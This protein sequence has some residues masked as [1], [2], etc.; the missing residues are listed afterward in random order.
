MFL[1]RVKYLAESVITPQGAFCVV[2]IIERIKCY[3]PGKPLYMLYFLGDV[4]KLRNRKNGDF[5]TTYLP[6][7]IVP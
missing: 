3:K 7:V 1:D 5:D 2:T 6:P 4:H